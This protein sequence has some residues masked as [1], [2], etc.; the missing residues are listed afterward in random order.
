MN[1][2]S[3]EYRA[4]QDLRKQIERVERELKEL[5]AREDAAF[6]KWAAPFARVNSLPKSVSMG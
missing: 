4:L 6:W 3:E 2:H 5:K 1:T